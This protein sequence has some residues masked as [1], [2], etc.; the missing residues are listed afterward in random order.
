MTGP[1]GRF[2]RAIS[3]PFRYTTPPSDPCSHSD[4]DAHMQSCPVGVLPLNEN[5]VR[6]YIARPSLVSRYCGSGTVMWLAMNPA[7]NGPMA[8]RQLDALYPTVTHAAVG[9]VLSPFVA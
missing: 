9:S 4:S 8:A 7:T 5:V 2:H 6:K 1:S 3:L